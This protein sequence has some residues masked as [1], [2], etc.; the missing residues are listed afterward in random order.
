[1]PQQSRRHRWA[2][3]SEGGGLMTG[4]PFLCLTARDAPKVG[5]LQNIADWFK[6]LEPAVHLSTNQPYLVWCSMT[7]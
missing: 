2:H 5:I 6:P 4:L 1:M 7:A 3:A